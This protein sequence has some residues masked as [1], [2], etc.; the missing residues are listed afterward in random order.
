[1]GEMNWVTTLVSSV[2]ALGG[3][4]AGTVAVNLYKAW[5]DDR[6]AGHGEALGE[7]KDL[8][9]TARERIAVLE[10]GIQDL[11]DTLTAKLDAADE[12]E[13]EC[14]V[15]FERVFS[16]MRYLENLCRDAKL[17]PMPFDPDGSAQHAALAP[18]KAV[19]R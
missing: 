15:K 9:A 18:D 10:K 14:L 7:W 12:R 11:R 3:L 16:Y 1:M 8:N 17:Q 19:P 2:V 13:H 5:R 6:R 4:G